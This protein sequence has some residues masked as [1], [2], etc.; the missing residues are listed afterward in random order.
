MKK[1]ASIICA[2][3]ALVSCTSKQQAPATTAQ[4]DFDAYVA[5]V[6]ALA[7]DEDSLFF[8]LSKKFYNAHP[9]DSLGILVF[10][11][12]AYYLSYDEL[13]SMLSTACD[14]IKNDPRFEHALQSKLAQ[15]ETAPGCQ[16]VD[17]EGIT[18]ATD[19]NSP[20]DGLDIRLSDIVKLGKPVLVDFWASW[21]GPCRRAIPHIAEVATKYQGQINVVGIAVWD[22]LADTRKAMTELPIS[23][24]VI[25][26]E[27]ASEPYGIEGIPHIMLIA[28][29]G[30]IL[31]RNLYGETIDA[32]IEEALK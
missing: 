8:D 22:K 1:L 5:A 19:V 7:D 29:D 20:A 24:P 18:V 10:R 3:V 6:Q 15:Q 14:E 16:Y 12:L 21:C 27:R 11:E 31:A 28:P 26:A 13:K 23:W 9:T 4:E 25:F 32:A 17:I 2:L 30:T